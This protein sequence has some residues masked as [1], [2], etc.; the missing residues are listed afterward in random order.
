M[1]TVYSM[2][3]DVEV[4]AALTSLGATPGNR[5]RIMREAILHLADARRREQLADDPE[6]AMQLLLNVEKAVHRAFG[7][8]G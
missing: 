2:R 8:T 3:A 1:A 4:D 7:V 6:A 5:S